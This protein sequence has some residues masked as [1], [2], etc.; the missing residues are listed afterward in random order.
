MKKKETSFGIIP[1]KKNPDWEILLVKHQKGHWAFPKGHAEEGEE[2]K[3]T[4]ERELKE[5]TGLEVVQYL[6]PEPLTERY[7]F[8][9]GGQGIEKTVYYFIALVKGV[10]KPQL[11]EIAEMRWLTFSQAERL[12]TFKE[13][14]TLCQILAKRLFKL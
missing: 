5:E 6:L 13:T 2:A 8:Q 1:L 11:E 10:L 3:K 7:F 9:Q 12:A 4:A 14:Q